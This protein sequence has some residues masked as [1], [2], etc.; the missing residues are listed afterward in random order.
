MSDSK[1]TS[2]GDTDAAGLDDSGM[3]LAGANI[4]FVED[5]EMLREIG[6]RSLERKGYKV[7]LAENGKTALD[8]LESNPSIRL[9]IADVIMPEMGGGAFYHAAREQYANLPF[10]FCSGYTAGVL[11]E[12]LDD[13][14]VSFIAK[15]YAFASLVA[16]IEL[17]LAKSNG[18]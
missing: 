14:L 15:P 6:K 11:D 8:L 16:A 7:L 13:D 1:N 18:V 17:L 3:S 12:I 9:V 10:L 2:D 4:L 5:D